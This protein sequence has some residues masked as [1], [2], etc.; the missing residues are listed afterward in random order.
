M[1]DLVRPGWGRR[2]GQLLRRACWVELEKQRDS[3]S[4]ARRSH[5]VEEVPPVRKQACH[6]LATEGSG[7]LAP[8]CTGSGTVIW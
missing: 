3:Q 4:E 5:L 2:E 8:P 7:L 1:E 6:L